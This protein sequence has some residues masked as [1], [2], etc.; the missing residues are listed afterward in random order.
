MMETIF[1]PPLVCLPRFSAIVA[2]AWL[3]A[4]SIL[5]SPMLWLALGVP[6]RPS[7]QDGHLLM[8]FSRL[9]GI[10]LYPPFVPYL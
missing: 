10:H 3:S 7:K 4:G 1:T 6:S 2:Q 8:L 9:A 5:L